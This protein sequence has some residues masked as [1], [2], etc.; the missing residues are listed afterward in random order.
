M[1]SARGQALATPWRPAEILGLSSMRWPVRAFRPDIPALDAFPVALWTRV[2]ARRLRRLEPDLL[3][4]GD[5]RGFR[6]LREEIATY[7][8]AA[9]GVR[10]EADQIIVVAGSQQ[11]LDLVARLCLDPGDA[12]WTEDPGYPGARRAFEAAGANVVSVP[13]DGDGLDVSAAM[14]RAPAAR[15]AFVTPAHQAPL[16]V[17]MSI[18]RRLALL[19]WAA[20]TGAWVLE[21]DYDSE[22]RYAGRPLPALQGL[23][24][25]GRVIY[26]GTFSKVLFPSLRLG[27]L[28]VP[29]ALVDAFAVARAAIDRHAPLMEQAVVADFMAAGHFARHVRR[30]RTLYAERQAALIQA[31]ERELSDVLDVAPKDAGLQLVGWL[32]DHADDRAAAAAAHEAGIETV[33]LSAYARATTPR[34]GLI[35]GYAAF[36]PT[37]IRTAAARLGHALRHHVRE[38]RRGVTRGA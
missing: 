8:G 36:T 30:M 10:C 14:A 20:A 16:G 7:L 31:A 38:S 17:A 34:P 1:L 4:R 24:E 18:T 12:V 26:L 23:D 2:A 19:D 3:A 21:D 35:L 5:P 9:R 15:L 25:T 27:F 29:P 37:R 13:V 11:G 22:Y 28:V 32:R 33:N 6:P